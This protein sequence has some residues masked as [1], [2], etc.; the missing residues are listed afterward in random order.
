M[1]F[2]VKLYLLLLRVSLYGRCMALQLLQKKR[3]QFK[4]L[5][6]GGFFL[7]YISHRKKSAQNDE[8]EREREREN[9]IEAKPK[10]ISN[11]SDAFTGWHGNTASYSSKSWLYAQAHIKKAS[12]SWFALW[13]KRQERLFM[14]CLARFF[15]LFILA[16]NEKRKK[17]AAS[18]NAVYQSCM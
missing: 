1:I 6:L 9:K 15:L 11:D 4:S 5:L 8:N 3:D 10:K 12:S 2:P 7:P 14:S 18:L 17:K 13:S 16:K